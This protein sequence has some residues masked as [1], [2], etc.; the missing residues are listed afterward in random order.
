MISFSSE[1]DYNEL[2]NRYG[3]KGNIKSAY[4]YAIKNHLSLDSLRNDYSSFI[5]SEQQLYLD[6]NGLSYITK[7]YTDLKGRN[8]FL[9]NLFS[10]IENDELNKIDLN[11]ELFLQKNYLALFNKEN[12]VNDLLKI[13]LYY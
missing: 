10:H 9:T 4:I 6:N 7:E 13:I 8:D 3:S 11:R 1:S 5:K 2:L 12:N